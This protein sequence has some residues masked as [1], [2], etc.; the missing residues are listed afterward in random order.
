M[1]N[2]T[3]ARRWPATEA[4]SSQ[5]H[6]IILRPL[7]TEKG[8]HRATRN[9][10]YAFEVNRWPTK[11]D[12][13]R[14]VEELFNVQGA[15]RAHAEPQGQA[16][17]HAVPPGA[18]EGLEEGDRH[19]RPG[20]PDRLLLSQPRSWSP[21]GAARLVTTESLKLNCHGNSP[22]QTDDAGTPRRDGQR[23]CRADA[24]A[25]SRRSRCCARSARPAAATTRARSPSRHRGG[26]HKRQYRLIDFRRNKDGVP[27]RVDID[28]VRSEPQCADRPVALRRRREALH[29]GAR[30]AEGGRPGGERARS[31]ADGRQ[32]PAADEDSA[33]HGDPQHRVAAGSRRRACAARPASARRWP[34]A[35]P[36]GPRSSCPAAKFAACRPPAGRRSARSAIA[37]HMSDRDRQGRA[38][39]LDGPAAARPRHGDEPDRPS[40]R[41]W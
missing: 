15:A 6:Q 27:A 41:R 30:R 12:V 11:D 25:P 9:N 7:V 1:D 24:R 16:A 21:A 19:A 22:I 26:G 8:M 39:S 10:A 4:R 5:P 13:R 17:P 31:A 18:D 38:Q 2:E 40:A 34:P 14:A 29:P 35:K 28:P 36:T 23:L 3:S 20:A 37:D 32:L 33:G